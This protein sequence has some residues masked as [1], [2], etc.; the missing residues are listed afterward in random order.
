MTRLTAKW[1]A[2]A[3]LAA[4]LA[5]TGASAQDYPTRPITL[6]VSTAAGGGNDIMA[7]VIGERMSRTLGQ[8]VVVENR[9]GAG[10]TIATKQVAKS[11]PDGYTLTLGNTGTLAQGPA[12]YPNAGYDPRKDFA[13]IGLIASAP[14]AIV[15]HP[16]VP[17]KTV[18]E[19]IALAKK[20]PDK[21]TYGSGGAGTPNHLTG[22]MFTADTGV[23]LTHVPFRG[24]GPAV[25]ALVGGHVSMMFAGLPSVLGNIKNE[26][27][28]VLATT[29]VKRAT[30]LPEIVTVAESGFPGFEAAQRYG[31]VAPAGT[32]QAIIDKLNAA[33]REALTSAD[34]KTRIAA[35]G[36]EPI[37]G[38][39]ADYAKD[40]DGELTKWTKV[41]QQAGISA[42]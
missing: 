27:V 31:L 4:A 8:Q 13:A 6:V 12:F 33:L 25:A 21:L 3:A 7:R 14:L 16:T 41:I 22:V 37:P 28:R 32:P 9:P 36:A 10:G 18:Q 29:S 15:V 24:S 11:A 38:T 34:V 39:P 19:L 42:K 5:A 23:S 26:Q 17:A 35:E 1:L 2:A 40:I 30:A 20:E